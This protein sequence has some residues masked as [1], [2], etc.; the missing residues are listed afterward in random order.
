MARFA[1]APRWGGGGWILPLLI[2]LWGDPALAA[3]TVGPPVGLARRAGFEAN[4]GQWPAAVRFVARDGAATLLL[5]DTAAIW[6]LPAARGAQRDAVRMRWAGARATTPRGEQ[7]R[8]A[9]V[10]YVRGPRR[11]WRLDVPLYARVVYR[12]VYPGVDLVFHDARGRLEYDFVVAAGA[13]ASVIRLAF[14][15]GVPQLDQAGGLSI[16]RPAAVLR[17]MPPLVFQDTPRGRRT[18]A[19]D[20]VVH[21]GGGAQGEVGFR[22]AAY[23]RRH[24]VVIDPQIE[25]ATR[26]DAI[27]DNVVDAAVD[28]AGNLWMVGV[29]PNP[30]FPITGD[31]AD[32]VRSTL[33]DNYVVRLNAAGELV[34]ATYL[35]G[36]SLNCIGGVAV[37]DEGNAYIAGSTI[38]TDFPV[39]PGAVQ[40]IAP[41]GGG[42]G[43]LAKLAPD[44]R[45]LHSTYFG[46]TNYEFCSGRGSPVASIAVAPDDAIYAVIGLTGS[47]EFPAAGAVRPS[48]RLDGDAL[49][50]RLDSDLRPV[51][52]RFLGSTFIDGFF[53]AIAADAA[54]NAYVLG[55]ANRTLGAA[56]DFP[57][58]PGAFQTTT[59]EDF[60]AVVAKYAPNGD[61]LYA[62]FLASTG[63]TA[64]SQ[65]YGDLAVAPDGTAY[66]AL[67]TGA[68]NMPVTPGAY[69]P[70]L[71]GFSD[72]F[73]AALKPDGSGLRYGTYLGGGAAEQPNTDTTAIAL[74]DQGQVIVGIATFSND[75]PLR[76]AFDTTPFENAV[77]KLSADGSALIYGSYV[78]HGAH[79]IAWR[80]NA[81]YVAGRNVDPTTGIGALKID[82]APAPC[83]GD[84]DGD[85]IVRVNELVIG[86][87]LALGEGGADDCRSFDADGDGSVSIAELIAAV[88]ALLNG[89]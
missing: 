1:R 46:G 56:H 14:E 16:A 62:T 49:I 42:D 7:A 20:W 21:R 44:G 30:S 26:V 72:L 80:N 8:P 66:V 68:A 22:L 2:G 51:W 88:G 15:G 5:T 78:R 55:K 61:L 29:T 86:V 48:T 32:P 39:T 57:V 3:P 71:R 27:T 19:G 60:P 73:I 36:S 31:A 84:C 47:S 33:D 75:F 40:D 4:Q 74:D 45:L 52:G 85:R 10:H 89:C 76:D 53:T 83:A 28:A 12:G 6:Q 43:F 50:A 38:S 69:Q 79:A 24:A 13:D 54:G 35:G 41:G 17:Q 82:E 67:H 64:S 77:A 18:V 34:Y 9:H 81:L 87:R 65:W 59:E 11:D 37:D 58:T 63:G 25:Y 23:D 70:T